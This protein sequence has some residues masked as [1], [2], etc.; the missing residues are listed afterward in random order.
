[1]SFKQETFFP[2]KE[3]YKASRYNS[4]GYAECLEVNAT[5][6]VFE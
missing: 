4:K 1:M 6:T 3:I 5:F 2:D